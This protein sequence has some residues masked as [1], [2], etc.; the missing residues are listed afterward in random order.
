MP[1]A[2]H[3]GMMPNGG[4]LVFI[5]NNFQTGNL[6]NNTTFYVAD[7]PSVLSGNIGPAST[8][9]SGTG[10]YT[11]SRNE[12]LIFNAFL[13]F[14]LKKL[15]VNAATA[16]IRII[17]LR[18]QYGHLLQEEMFPLVTGVQD[19]TLGFLCSFRIESSVRLIFFQPVGFIIYAV[20]RQLP[21]LVFPLQ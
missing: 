15:R 7:Q 11:A 4:N 10:N 19:V 1:V 8:T 5:G 20:L 3:I 13:P 6:F 18:D 9:F 12:Y 16:G 17:Q 14:K 21:I 2:M